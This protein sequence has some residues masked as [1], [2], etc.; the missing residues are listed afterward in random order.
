[1]PYRKTRSGPTRSQHAVYAAMCEFVRRERRPP[2]LTEIAAVM[3]TSRPNL[4]QRIKRLAEMGWVERVVR[5]RT[6]ALAGCWRPRDVLVVVLDPQTTRSLRAAA[7]A[8]GTS[9]EKTLADIAA[10]AMRAREHFIREM[11][12]A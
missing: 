4:Q 11:E 10:S 3:G 5:G 12:D 8:R 7:L 6:K 1:M 9:P 2:T